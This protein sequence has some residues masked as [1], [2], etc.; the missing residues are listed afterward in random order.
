M[1]APVVIVGASL[2]GLRS[3]EGL[4][5]AGYA[6]PITVVGDEAHAPYNRPPLSKGVLLSDDGIDALSFPPR[7][8]T[9]DV[10][11][12]LGTRVLSADLRDGSVLTAA[13]EAI[14]YRAL[15]AATGVRPARIA[16]PAR[17]RPA[18]C[19][20]LRTYD[21]ALGLRRSLRAGSRV[22]IAGA[23]FIGCEVA[24]AAAELG[25]EVTVVGA[26]SAPMQRS[27]GT[28][29]A[30]ELMR[31]HEARGVAFAM[32]TRV[33]GMLGWPHI[34]GVT[35]DDGSELACDAL[36]EAI[37]TVPNTEWLEGN[38]IDL[39]HGVRTDSSLRALR[40]S[41]EAWPDVYAVGDVARFPHALF[42]A[43]DAMV[44]HWNIPGETARQASSALAHR[45]TGAVAADDD[46][47]FA[48][49]P[50]FWS[51]QGPV[52][53]L[54]YGVLDDADRRELLDGD[55]S[56]ACVYGYFRGEQLVGVCGIGARAKVMA[57]RNSIAWA[58]PRLERIAAQQSSR[59][60]T[61]S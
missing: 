17:G 34:T 7:P 33:T 18:G 60:E 45:L 38:D 10:E 57:Y 59:A 47:P 2:G 53:I 25:C 32:G 31:R 51:D 48:P 20:A 42:A 23:G 41:G 56:G 50:T 58:P 44:G 4:R 54:A 46:Q 52:R 24:A 13:G 15:I 30:T 14:S 36:L 55:L 12:L 8:S 3:A 1:I 11:W 27:L 28:E 49:M 29:L 43:G 22:V 6:G 9:S 35:L 61:A 37:G 26:G 16:A 19:F 5:R 21:D 39:G 40:R